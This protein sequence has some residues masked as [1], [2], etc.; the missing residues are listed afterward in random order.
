[1]DVGSLIELGPFPCSCG[2]VHAIPLEK[3]VMRP[4]AIN[5]LAPLAV[6][7]G[8][9]W[10]YLL[11]DKQTHTLA[12]KQVVEFLEQA[13]IKTTL[14]VF[15]HELVEPDELS[16]GEAVLHF[17]H[18]CNAI[19]AIGSGTINDIGKVVAYTSKLPYWIVATAPSM[20]GYASGS[21]SMV[22]NQLKVTI[23]TMCPQVIIAD[24]DMLMQAPDEMILAG[25]GDMCSKYISLLEWRVSNLVTDEYYCPVVADLMRAA[26]D[27]CMAVAPIARKREAHTIE[28]IIEGLVIAGIAAAYAGISRPASGVEHY[29]SHLLDMHAIGLGKQPHLHGIQVALG[30][31]VAR[32]MWRFIASLGPIEQQ[33]ARTS[34]EHVDRESWYALLRETFGAG[35]ESMVSEAKAEQ[36]YAVVDHRKRLSRILE[37]REEIEEL[38]RHLL[39]DEKEFVDLLRSIGLPTKFSE[40][41]VN[42]ELAHM[43]I[44]AT[45]DVRWK[46]IASTLLDDLGHLS[47]CADVIVAEMA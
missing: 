2:K 14:H 23:N 1:M 45:K 4:G 3:M 7:H 11:A 36:R 22:R 29:V 31:V 24:T 33:S 47:A 34:Y 16:V 21:S 46:Y 5:E 32:K 35:G 40:L 12:G 9:S 10:V 42:Q 43:I 8:F 44:R 19:I 15:E 39:P 38:S 17:P 26:L 6:A 30:T 25:I 37:H 41:G 20:D 18:G 28:T 27:R 13:G